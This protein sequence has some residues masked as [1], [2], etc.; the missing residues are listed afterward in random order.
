[1]TSASARGHSKE[2]QFDSLLR[3]AG[4]ATLGPPQRTRFNH[5]DH[6]GL[7]DNEAHRV[8][9]PSLFI[10]NTTGHHAA[11]KK[12]EIEVSEL[13]TRKAHASTTMLLVATWGHRKRTG[14]A[15]K[16]E[17]LGNGD[18]RGG[19]WRTLGFVRIS[20]EVVGE[21]GDGELLTRLLRKR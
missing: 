9:S 7:F 3:A 14:A 19:A 18:G 12:R 17:R 16:V 10:S 5:H 20:G 8:S 6:Y 13:F 1:M 21:E 4:W 15:W 2:A 11:D